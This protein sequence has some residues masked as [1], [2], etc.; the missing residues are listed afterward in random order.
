MKSASHT[1]SRENLLVNVVRKCTKLQ[2]W[3]KRKEVSPIT[4]AIFD[5]RLPARTFQGRDPRRSFSR[6]KVDLTCV[7]WSWHRRMWNHVLCTKYWLACTMTLFSYWR[8]PLSHIFIKS[9]PTRRSV[10][11]SAVLGLGARVH[12]RP[13]RNLCQISF[14]SR[15]SFVF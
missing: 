15:F 1:S 10:E 6:R 14:F 11:E 5:L 13:P 7:R 12:I 8:S 2:P 3:G 9:L 4:V